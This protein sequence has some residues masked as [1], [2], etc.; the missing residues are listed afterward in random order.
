M[1]TASRPAGLGPGARSSYPGAWDWTGIFAK[2]FR[3]IG[4]TYPQGV[5]GVMDAAAAVSAGLCEVALVVGGQAGVLGG[6]KVASYTRPDNEFVSVWG[7]LTSAHFALIA[8]VYM[9]RF[10]PDR[11]RLSRG[12][13]SH[14]QCGLGQSQCQS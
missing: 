6:P 3:W 1:S 8:Q 4:D 2:P 11:D 13:R 7:M 5:P 12:G 9:H 14:P 10:S